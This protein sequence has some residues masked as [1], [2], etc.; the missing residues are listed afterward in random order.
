MTTISC[1]RVWDMAH[2][3][4]ALLC[5]SSAGFAQQVNAPATDKDDDVEEI[6][7]Y[8]TKDGD[9]K[10]IETRHEA[11]LRAAI[12]REYERLRILEE[13][14]AWRRSLPTGA[15]TPSRI[16]W[17]YDAQA[18]LRMRKDSDLMNLPI[19]NIRAASVIRIEF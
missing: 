9:P 1:G 18:E 17:G 7:V 4:V 19:D 16:K 3:A 11:L 5:F 12:I 15:E 14:E 2:A 8:A 10:D 6:V 13:Q